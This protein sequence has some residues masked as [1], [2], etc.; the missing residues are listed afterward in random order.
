MVLNFDPAASGASTEFLIEPK[1][2]FPHSQLD[3]NPIWTFS[4]YLVLLD[5]L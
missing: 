4:G 3:I 5:L 2:E 1:S